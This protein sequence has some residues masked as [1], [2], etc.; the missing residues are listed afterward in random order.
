MHFFGE[1]PPFDLKILGVLNAY[2]VPILRN[3]RVVVAPP[4]PPVQPPLLLSSSSEAS[5][6]YLLA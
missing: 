2:I 3:I 4:A 1:A 6:A 5:A